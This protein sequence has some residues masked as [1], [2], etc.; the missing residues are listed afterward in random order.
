MK[1]VAFLQ[2]QWFNDP[3]GVKAMLARHDHEPIVR[4][5]V[6]RCLIHYE[7]FAGCVTGR[8]LEKAFGDLTGK[9]VWEEGSRVISGNARDFH[10][11]DRVHIAEVIK[12]QQ[13]RVILSFGKSN[14]PIIEELSHESR[15]VDRV[16]YLPHPAARQATVPR[17]LAEAAEELRSWEQSYA[18]LGES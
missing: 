3:E 11:P 1:I 9:I 8:R 13:P 16:L 12:T 14:H 15:S 7:L 17:V 2:N 4:E 10:P 6:R 5:R 18:R